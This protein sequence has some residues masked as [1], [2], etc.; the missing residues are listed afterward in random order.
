MGKT[1]T[2]KKSDRIFL[3]LLSSFL[4]EYFIHHPCFAF[5]KLDN[6]YFWLYL[7]CENGM[8]MNM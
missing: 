8:P 5:P 1:S 2:K 4:A 3:H 7:F 6:V